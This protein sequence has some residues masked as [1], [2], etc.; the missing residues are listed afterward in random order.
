MSYQY[1][2]LTPVIYG[3]PT[4]LFGA[5][6]GLLLSVLL[7]FLR[8]LEYSSVTRILI[9]QELGAVD[10]YTASR[11][12]ERIADDLANV[13]Y[14]STFYDKVMEAPFDIDESYFP[15]DD[16]KKR[17]A[18]EKAVTISVT[19]GTGLLTIT[20]Y[21]TDVAQAEQIA[22]GVAG[23]LTSEGWTYTSG[24]NITVKVVDEPLD[25]KWPVRPNILINAFS[26]FVLGALGGVG[27]ILIQT[28][29]M[30]RRHQFIHDSDPT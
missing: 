1:T 22:R 16:K 24:G 10:A 28:E 25:S 12:A 17:E 30:K 18:W 4:I 20:A 11:S 7:S 3:W 6:I 23:V 19:R 26:G 5:A 29:R 15:T 9:T 2:K 13:V 27:Y 14:T 8:P 21:H